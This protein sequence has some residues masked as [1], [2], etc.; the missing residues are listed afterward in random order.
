MLFVLVPSS[1]SA[2]LVHHQLG[3]FGAL[4]QPVFAQAEGLAVDQSTG[5]VLVVDAGEGVGT[6][7]RYHED[8]SPADFSALGT[9]VITVPGLEFASFGL[10]Q[11]AVDDSG[12][13][14]DGDIYV[15]IPDG[16]VKI[17]AAD[18]EPLTELTESKEGPFGYA[19]GVGVDSAGAVYVVDSGSEVVHKFVPA[20]N[21]PVTAD[22]TANFP[23]PGGTCQVT[24]GAGPTAG[25]FFTVKT[26]ELEK[27]DS[28]T[29][30][31][32]YSVTPPLFG[33][34]LA[35][36]DP[37]DGDV[38]V[39]QREAGVFEYD[40]SEASGASRRSSFQPEGTV[41][42]LAVNGS[43][44]DVYVAISGSPNIEV[45]SPALILPDVKAEPATPVND[46]TLVLHGTINAAEGPAA[47]C[48]FEYTT[49]AAFEEKGFAGAT[50]AACAPAGLFTGS[51]EESVSAEVGGLTAGVNYVFRL[52]GSNAN[53]SNPEPSSK[54][55]A[56]DFHVGPKIVTSGVADVTATAA[57]VTAEFEP[58]GGEAASY[59][60]EYGPT[61]GYGSSHPVPDA[62][63][64]VPVGKGNFEEGQ[65]QVELVGMSQ[66]TF[67]V[68]QKI[69]GEGI[70]A[71]TTIT[72]IEPRLVNGVGERL[73][74]T[75]SKTVKFGNYE[76]TLS[77]PTAVV[78]QR[79]TGLA[80]GSLYH[81]RVVAAGIGVSAGSDS[82][83]STFPQET[84]GAGRAYELVSPAVKI[85]EPFPPE[86][87]NGFA[88]LCGT[89]CMPG[90][91]SI[92]MPMQASADGE[93]LAY[94]GQPFTSGLASS[95]NQ[96]IAH[97]SAGGWSTQS[98]TPSL[99]AAA[100]GA[101][102]NG[103]KAFSPDLSRGVLFQTTPALS[104]E[105]P[106]SGGK[107]SYHDLYLWEVG[108]SSLQP[109]V[110][111]KPPHRTPGSGEPTSFELSFAGGNSGGG[112]VPAFDH[113]VF[114]A[115]D[116]LTGAVP[117]IA[118]AAPEVE[119]SHCSGYPAGG[120]PESDCDLYEWVGGQLHLINVLP[121]NEAAATHA[122]IGSG[123]SLTE[124]LTSKGAPESQAPDVDHAISA[125]GSRIFWSDESGQ[126]YVRID[127]RETVQIKDPGR[128]L[129]A[130]SD[131]S[132]VLLTDG[133]L[134]SLQS[135]S[136]EFTLGNSGSAFLGT[137]GTS[138][139]LSRVYFIDS[140]ALAPGSQSGESCEPEGEERE[141]EGCNLYAFDRG[142]V[143]FIAR[144]VGRDN[145]FPGFARYGAWKASPGGRVAQ[146]TPDGRYLTFMSRARLTEYD[147]R[148]AGGGECTP[149]GVSPS[150]SEVYEY[151]LT[152]HSLHCASCNPS[153]QSPIG[154]STLALINPNPGIPFEQP[155]NLPAEGEG[156]LF[157]ESQDA[158]LPAAKNGGVED[159]YE[160]T[161]DG[162]GGCGRGQGCLALIS[163]GHSPDDSNFITATPNGDNAF[164][165]TREQL[166]P[167]DQDDLLDVYDA[168]VGGG[169]DVG[170]LAPCGGE[171]CRAPVSGG[172]VVQP[173]GSSVF[174]GLGGLVPVPGS[175]PGVGVKPKVKPM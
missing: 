27:V 63:V 157:F 97:R 105:V 117:G 149:G 76:T 23:I 12:G 169:S 126:V 21:P 167:E 91:N 92:M 152:S 158:L 137:L 124:S 31:Y 62:S 14:A 86:P 156:R 4:D 61:A 52:V 106:A 39:S 7:S 40:A 82:T 143:T 25:F 44:G 94:E 58:N 77:S 125:D 172:S 41:T 116:S 36:V 33:P 173:P 79:L 72:K 9:N 59:H 122:T 120:F 174:S 93:T 132:K 35:A 166:V 134:Y 75:L 155:E 160:W 138:A 54:E 99:A 108:K 114:E 74:L 153:G 42:G 37:S 119:A 103:F 111:T 159:V 165:I 162:V 68:G 88:R 78:S 17:F 148:R 141:G 95:A 19:C 57:T 89:E 107:E 65:A 3:R 133:C 115:N 128:F 56:T 15:A 24:I 81:F 164:F 43:S 5:D 131:G 28:A 161:P 175:T 168:R 10:V 66:G 69:V 84:G 142:E 30:V 85:G 11:V 1:A 71:G 46:S 87:Q 51:G 100:V 146:V 109:L 98:V 135:K 147:N 60:V 29:G 110:T 45:W 145:N 73:F 163:G 80:S 53:G 20:G 13:P 170:P 70:E 130:S 118:P 55:G 83:F 64:L 104:P 123:R 32:Q 16:P 150:C 144:L 34:R 48:E 90:V 171:G 154:T 26:N 121:G 102:G 8:G 38:F 140:E 47:T 151:D 129:T 139:D 101:Q 127:G 50:S 18:G 2:L 49:E 113:L 96:Y 136:C 22:N 112:G 67:A 6:L